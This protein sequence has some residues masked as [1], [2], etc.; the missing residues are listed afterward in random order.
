MDEM[1][2]S[3]REYETLG[4]VV[5][6]LGQRRAVQ[7]LARLCSSLALQE[8]L[9]AAPGYKRRSDVWQRCHRELLA[10]SL[11]L[12]GPVSDEVRTRDCSAL[13]RIAQRHGCG[14]T[15]IALSRITAPA[16]ESSARRLQVLGD[17]V[18]RLH[19]DPR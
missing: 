8:E 5:A 3:A 12:P 11:R 18:M 16:D 1:Q 14:V 13:E 2:M 6:S 4:R 17:A 10:G 15:L 19:G 7:V 9:M